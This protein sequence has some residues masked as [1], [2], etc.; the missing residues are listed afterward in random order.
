MTT[1][2]PVSLEVGQYAWWRHNGVKW[3][4]VITRIGQEEGQLVYDC[5]IEM[6]A[7]PTWSRKR[8]GYADEYEPMHDTVFCRNCGT[9]WTVD[10]YRDDLARNALTDD[11]CV[12]SDGECP[13]CGWAGDIVEVE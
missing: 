12:E 6:S 3:P 2:A 9:V 7:E 10:E 11:L 8:W 13:Y 1:R 5:E 4:C